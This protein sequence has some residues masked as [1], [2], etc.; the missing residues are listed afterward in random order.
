MKELVTKLSLMLLG[1][2]L[3]GGILYGWTTINLGADQCKASIAIVLCIGVFA[4]CS[5]VMY[6]A[7]RKTQ[8][9]GFKV[10]DIIVPAG[11]KNYLKEQL[12]IVQV[13]EED[14]SYIVSTYYGS[15]YRL[16][17]FKAHAYELDHHF[18]IPDI[19]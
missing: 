8:L 16:P 14:G 15:V 7:Y 1:L 12:T 2:C 10:G 3:I 17:F 11:H 5:A 13:N 19:P 9:K 18:N 4:A 6:R